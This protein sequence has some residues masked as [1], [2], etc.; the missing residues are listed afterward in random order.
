M[1]PKEFSNIFPAGIFTVRPQRGVAPTRQQ[2]EAWWAEMQAKGEKQHLVDAAILR[3]RAG[4]RRARKLVEK[5]PDAA[6][7]AIEAGFE[8]TTNTAIRG[9]Y[10]EVAGGLPGNTPVAFLR[11]KLA[12]ENGLYSQVHAAEA[13]FARSQPEAIPAMIAAWRNVQPRLPADEADAYS[14]VGGLITF[15]AKSGDAKA[16]DALGENLKK[17]PVDVRLA[18]VQV[19][20]PWL[21]N[22]GMS[23]IG[24]SVHVDADIQK[25]PAGAASTRRSSACALSALDDP[26]P[27]LKMQ[28]NYNEVA[29][30]DPRICDMAALVLS[31]RWPDK[32]RFQW[33]AN[34][35]ERDAQTGACA[36]DKAFR[37]NARSSASPGGR[38]NIFRRRGS[39]EMPLPWIAMPFSSAACPCCCSR[40]A[41][42]P[43]RIL[44]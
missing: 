42:P 28:G 8:A 40:L 24:R 15:L 38:V 17:A 21:K 10:V 6:L 1:S 25:L 31:K 36:T 13:L 43:P 33:V 39:N 12:P 11:S 26:T 5:Y 4:L 20:L 30:E 35:A 27:R 32:Y 29:Y 34:E 9:R 19:S 23:A 14:E 44:S 16:I 37:A 2:A 41:S 3:W 22:G 7:D 18:I